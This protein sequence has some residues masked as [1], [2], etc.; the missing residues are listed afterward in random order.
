MAVAE[1][2]APCAV[3][4]FA[5]GELDASAAVSLLGFEEGFVLE[6]VLH[7]AEVLDGLP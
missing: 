6:D 4:R 1:V 7:I 3:G 2:G 5:V